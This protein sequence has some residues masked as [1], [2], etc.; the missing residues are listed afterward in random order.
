MDGEADGSVSCPAGRIETLHPA[1]TSA[2][3]RHS[4]ASS[5]RATLF[6]LLLACWGSGSGPAWSDLIGTIAHIKPSVIPFGTYQPTRNPAFRFLGTAFAVGDGRLVAITAHALP[7]TV[8][9]DAR[10]TL[11][12]LLADGSGRPGSA[13]L[14]ELVEQDREHDVALLRLKGEPLPALTLSERPAS[15]GQVFAFTGFPIGGALG[16]I[17]VTHQALL[18]AV[19]P[20]TMPT[21]QARQLDPRAVR[22]LS[23]GAFDIYQLDATAYPGSSGSPLYDPETGQVVAIVNMVFVKGARENVLSQPSGISYAI[24]ARYL[25]DLLR[26]AR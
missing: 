1:A 23:R 14:V 22:Q 24:P 12:V 2:S 5:R 25:A 6:W 15:E 10:E 13:R 18:A 26:R 16:F 11:A 3:T 9:V 17:P 7:A 21:Q 8:D 4:P 19:V 20:I